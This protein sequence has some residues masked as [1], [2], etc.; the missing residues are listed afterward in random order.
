MKKGYFCFAEFNPLMQLF[1]EKNLRTPIR[2]DVIENLDRAG[3]Q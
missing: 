1:V 3:S 2:I